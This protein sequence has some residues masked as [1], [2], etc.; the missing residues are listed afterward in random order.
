MPK[1]GETKTASQFA[2]LAGGKGANSII[3]G[4][5]LGSK[6]AFISK[7]WQFVV[8]AMC[9]DNFMFALKIKVGQWQS[10]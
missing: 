1:I 9:I 2:C 5:R 3:S 6:N 4:S 8:L 7:V 10:G